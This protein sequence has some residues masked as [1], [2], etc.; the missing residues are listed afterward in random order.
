[1]DRLRRH[2]QGTAQGRAELLIPI[3]LTS[4][5][6]N[7]E[8]NSASADPGVSLYGIPTK[9]SSFGLRRLVSG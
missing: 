6:I 4:T 8:Y 5:R 7:A 2:P 3:S 1:M 9:G